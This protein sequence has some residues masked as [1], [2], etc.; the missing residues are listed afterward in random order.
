[1]ELICLLRDRDHTGWL[2]GCIREQCHEEKLNETDGRSA[3][4]VHDV[5]AS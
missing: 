5:D 4:D 1:M 3:C 2:H